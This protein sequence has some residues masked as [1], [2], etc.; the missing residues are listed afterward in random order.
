MFNEIE[1]EDPCYNGLSSL[2]MIARFPNRSIVTSQDDPWG[3][4]RKSFVIKDQL[5][6]LK[7]ENNAYPRGNA[8]DLPFATFEDYETLNYEH[9][10]RSGLVA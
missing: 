9:S 5:R 7:E 10:L 6:W 3:R 2:G 1:R 4:R 8:N